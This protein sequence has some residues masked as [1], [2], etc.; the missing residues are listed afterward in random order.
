M[1]KG[2]SQNKKYPVFFIITGTVILVIILSIVSSFIY[3][4]FSSYTHTNSQECSIE[5]NNIATKGSSS[6][7][8]APVACLL[9][10]NAT[11]KPSN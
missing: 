6:M 5:S 9:D 4:K 1:N 2:D 11:Y 3:Q 7:N 8:E 10:P